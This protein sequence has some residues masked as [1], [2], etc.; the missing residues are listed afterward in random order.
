MIW[1]SKRTDL[2][3]ASL[4]ELPQRAVR[5]VSMYYG[6]FLSLKTPSVT[7]NVMTDASRIITDIGTTIRRTLKLIDAPSTNISFRRKDFL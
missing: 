6:D 5:P 3:A 1:L 7:L 2:L 4:I